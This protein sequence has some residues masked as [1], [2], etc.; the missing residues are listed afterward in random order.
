M[1]IPRTAAQ[2]DAETDVTQL[3]KCYR[4]REWFPRLRL[5]A[6]VCCRRIWD[7]IPA[8]A[9]RDAVA[10]AE[11]FA[12]GQATKAELRAAGER[13]YAVVRS[14]QTVGENSYRYGTLKEAIASAAWA[15]TFPAE[16][17]AVE[18]PK[19]VQ[20]AIALLSDPEVAQVEAGEQA[21]LLRESVGH[22][23]AGLLSR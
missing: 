23:F 5:F 14:T 9:C 17:P 1:P 12:L 4:G 6:V 13:A 3:A 19:H 21:A 15:C 18:V 8:G 20:R 7:H 10:T 22:P 2:W 16:H 11:R